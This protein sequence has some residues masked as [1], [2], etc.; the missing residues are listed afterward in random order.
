MTRAHAYLE[1]VTFGAD[2]EEHP[3]IPPSLRVTVTVAGVPLGGEFFTPDVVVRHSLVWRFSAAVDVDVNAIP[4][5]VT[6]DLGDGS[7]LVL[8]ASLQIPADEVFIERELTTPYQVS[9]PAEPGGETRGARRHGRGRDHRSDDAAAPLA[10]TLRAKVTIVLLVESFIDGGDIARGTR[11]ALVLESTIGPASPGPTVSVWAP[12]ALATA[13]VSWAPGNGWTTVLPEGFTSLSSLYMQLGTM[14]DESGDL[15]GRVASLGIFAHGPGGA[16]S[17][18]G[19]ELYIDPTL[20]VHAL[21][22]RP[23]SHWALAR[24]VLRLLGRSF[25]TPDAQVVLFACG[26][27]A[28][29]GGSALLRELSLLLPGRTVIGFVTTGAFAHGVSTAGNVIDT[30]VTGPPGGD[31]VGYPRFEPDGHSA[32]HAMD[33]SIVRWENAK[34]MYVAWWSRRS[35]DERDAA[36]STASRRGRANTFRYYVREVAGLDDDNPDVQDRDHDPPE[37]V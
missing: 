4:V 20:N 35:A 28:G 25:L 37:P 15:R 29:S 10:A 19:G 8:S 11:A 21:R 34:A 3:P 13:G 33:G 23:S 6:I 2:G 32:K 22:R 5:E 24:R 1:Y 26:G 12:H 16:S 9:A 36:R 14:Q 27:A 17:G 7:P 30:L 31:L 18:N